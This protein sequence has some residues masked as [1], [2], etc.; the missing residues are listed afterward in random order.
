MT[1]KICNLISCK[2]KLIITQFHEKILQGNVGKKTKPKQ[3]CYN[4]T[5]LYSGKQLNL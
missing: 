3:I 2:T 4:V 1:I 5:G